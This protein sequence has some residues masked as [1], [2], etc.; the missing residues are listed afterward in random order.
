MRQYYKIKLIY[1]LY[2]LKRLVYFCA[3]FLNM[4]QRIQSIY[5]FI[6]ILLAWLVAFL[7]PFWINE[8]SEVIYLTSLFGNEEMLYMGIP[9]LFIGSG[10]I[11]FLSL[12][13]FKYRSR[14]IISNRINI[15]INF[16]LLGI[17]VY[18]LLSLPGETVVS[19]KGIGVFIPLLVIVFLVLSNK[20]I[21][22]DEKLVK[23]V[24]RLR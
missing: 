2:F 10:I 18:H 12:V 1:K 17:I 23:S 20:A 21:I 5:M 14:Q 8:N 3:S 22:K 13:S 24:D 15:V 19:E 4:L 9:F 11:S 7:I 6:A 16:L